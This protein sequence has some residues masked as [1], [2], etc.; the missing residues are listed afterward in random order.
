MSI[1]SPTISSQVGR[2][3]TKTFNQAFVTL[4]GTAFYILF[5]H[6]DNIPAPFQTSHDGAKYW[7]TG[8]VGYNVSRSFYVFAEGDGIFQRFNNSVFNT[9]GYR[10]IGG[11]GSDDPRVCSVVKSMADI[12][13]RTAERRITAGC[14]RLGHPHRRQQRCLWWPSYLLPDPVLDDYG[15]VDQTLGISTSL[16][17]SVPQGVPTRRPRAILQTTYGISRIG[18]SAPGAATRKATSLGCPGCNNHG[19]LAGASFNYEI[20]RNLLLTL[21]YQYTTVQLEC[22]ILQFYA[23][24]GTLPALHTGTERGDLDGWLETEL[25]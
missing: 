3:V 16:S 2:S 17:P 1:P 10:V 11:V 5:D 4:G 19:W 13:L 25:E 24:Y 7:V 8:R 20:W 6:P 18:R 21:D 23:Q 9:N 12:R 14:P 15:A 22:G